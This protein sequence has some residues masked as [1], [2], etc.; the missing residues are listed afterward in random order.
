MEKFLLISNV[1]LWA[2][3]LA[4]AFL[5]IGTL[6]GYGVLSWKLEQLELTTPR[7]L[8]RTG[9]AL[10]RVAPDFTLPGTAGKNVSLHDFTGRKVLLVFM[11][12]GCRP[13]HAVVPELNRLTGRG[14]H[15]VLVVN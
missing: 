10:G 4:L 12:A 11:Q 15:Q 9:L 13:C 2:L 1:A 6:R 8:G 3:T 5:L 14:S 7:R